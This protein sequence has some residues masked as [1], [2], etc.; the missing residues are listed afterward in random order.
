MSKVLPFT[1][2]SL[3]S[4]IVALIFTLSF[5]TKAAGQEALTYGS[6]ETPVV[7]GFT[8]NSTTGTAAGMV[9][10]STVEKNHQLVSNWTVSQEEKVQGYELQGS[11][12]G[13]NFSRIRF[14]TAKKTGSY[15]MVNRRP[16]SKAVYY[17]LKVIKEDGNFGYSTVV[18]LNTDA[19][20][21]IAIIS[22]PAAGHS[23]GN[24]D[25]G[26]SEASVSLTTAGRL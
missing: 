11:S 15:S 14:V 13:V 24:T 1:R 18:T 25:A 2:Y 23:T 12:D 3:L 16:S 26:L 22:I 9:N 7:N 5:G 10:F 17:R 8:A 4:I 21:G 6:S 19:N 20:T